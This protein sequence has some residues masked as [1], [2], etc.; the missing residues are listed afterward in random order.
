[1]T[2]INQTIPPFSRTLSQNQLVLTR[3]DTTT[4]Q[5]NMGLLCNQECRH[6]HLDAGPNR[7]EVM[8]VK[9][10]QEVI[11]FARRGKFQIADITGGAPEL[12]PHL[13]LLIQEISP[14][15]PRMML[16]SNLTALNDRKQESLIPLLKEYGVVIIASFPSLNG[17]RAD[18]QRGPGIFQKSIRVLQSLNSLGYGREGS[19]LELNLVVNPTG[20]GLPS[21]QEKTEK[22]FREGLNTKWGV[23]FNH[24]YTLANVPLGRFLQDLVQSMTLNLYRQELFRAFNP[25]ALAGVMCRSTVSVSWD[26]TLFDCDFNLARGLFMGGRKTH[27]SELSGPPLP[28]QPIAVSDHCYA[29]TAGTGFT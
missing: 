22:E 23:V 15:I 8:T 9:T 28:G 27:I 10:V 6:C 18:T 11:E 5:I 19:G 3:L 24:L 1:M 25:A 16:R 13:P 2:E 7:S 14:S 20:T 26:G 29:C 17:P 12:N 21:P 4:L